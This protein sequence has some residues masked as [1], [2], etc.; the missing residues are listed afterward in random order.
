AVSDFAAEHRTG[1]VSPV[2]PVAVDPIPAEVLI[3]TV[4]EMVR[5]TT[6][7]IKSF[8]LAVAT[9]PGTHE[10]VVLIVRE[11]MARGRELRSIY[12]LSV[13]DHSEELGW[14]R[15]WAAV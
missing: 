14:V 6:G 11:Q 1:G 3:T 10:G 13:L 15:D 12:P 9:G 7:V 2:S 4:E 5:S 8:H